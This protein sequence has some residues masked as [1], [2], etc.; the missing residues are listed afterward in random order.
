M[1]KL[2]HH[3]SK[4][5]PLAIFLSCIL[6][7]GFAQ[8]VTN[9][10]FTLHN[11]IRGD[12]VYNTF[13]KQ[14]EL[15]KTAGFAG[16]EIN[17]I[18]SFEGMKAAL[19]R[20]QLKGSYFYVKL[21]LEEPYIDA[22]LR[23]CIGKLKGSKTIIAPY[24]LSESKKYKPSTHDADTLVVRLVREI[25]D[26]AKEAGLEVAIYPHLGY[27]VERTD[28]ALDLVKQINRKNVG[29]TFNLCHYLATSSQAERSE[30]K[31]HLK[32]LKPYL[33]MITVSGANDVMSQ[34]K[35]VWEDYILPL[36][37]GSYDTYGLIKYMVKDL[38]FKNPIGV[39][40]YNIRGKKVTLIQNTMTAWKDYK[41]R[42]ET[43]K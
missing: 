3:Y 22:R 32:Q 41:S 42:L 6:S 19:D 7:I 14:V 10:F 34:Q 24:I 21:K 11:I 18:E 30:V 37:T 15:L 5:L 26:W 28:H 36:G 27:Y 33:K 31:P 4:S 39:Q 1:N 23:K 16:V 38:K 12:S 29:L 40:C 9:D 8:K 25:G 2:D 13:D 20:Y 43:D 35:N 17:Q